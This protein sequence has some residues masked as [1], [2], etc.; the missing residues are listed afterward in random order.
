M[1]LGVLLCNEDCGSAAQLA[2]APRIELVLDPLFAVTPVLASCARL[3]SA[4]GGGCLPQLRLF[5]SPIS[6]GRHYRVSHNLL[7]RASPRERSSPAHSLYLG[8]LAMTAQTEHNFSQLAHSSP[9][10]NEETILSIGNVLTIMGISRATLTRWEDAGEC[11]G[12]FFKIRR[13]KFTTAGQLRKWIR[14]RQQAAS[15]RAA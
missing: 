9:I 12:L 5:V 3:H 15:L 10:M 8:R 2:T 7:G 14:E 4:A 13:R 11:D 1:V 6:G